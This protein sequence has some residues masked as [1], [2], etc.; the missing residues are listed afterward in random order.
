MRELPRL[1]TECDN[2]DRLAYIEEFTEGADTGDLLALHLNGELASDLGDMTESMLRGIDIQEFDFEKHLPEDA[3]FRRLCA[4]LV[5]PAID[6]IL[7]KRFEEA[8]PI[9]S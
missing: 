3:E 2:D 5:T 7:H 4:A 8:R 9:A 6:Y 1:L